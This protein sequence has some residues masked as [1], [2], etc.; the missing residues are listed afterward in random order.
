MKNLPDTFKQFVAMTIG[1]PFIPDMSW[2]VIARKCSKCAAQ[3]FN[4]DDN[5]ADLL[6]VVTAA[7]MSGAAYELYRRI[8]K[9]GVYSNAEKD[10]LEYEIK[11]IIEDAS[12]RGFLNEICL[13]KET[14]EKFIDISPEVAK[15]L[16]PKETRELME[17]RE[18]LGTLKNS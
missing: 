13:P 12:K 8:E 3:L 14:V 6:Q 15:M 5:T 11:S 16:W 2:E 7:R 17:L 4:V 1:F 9:S 18:I 10:K